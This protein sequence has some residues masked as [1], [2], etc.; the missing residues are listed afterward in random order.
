MDVGAAGGRGNHEEQ[1]GRFVVQTFVIDTVTD[2]H[3]GQTRFPDG[4]RLGMGD[5]DALAD[6]GAAFLFAV[7]DALFVA[8]FIAQVAPFFHEV[9]QVVDGTGLVR[10]TGIQIDALRFQ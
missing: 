10:Y 1:A 8:F 9:H 5:G 6:A 3:G 7:Q 4:R 2:N